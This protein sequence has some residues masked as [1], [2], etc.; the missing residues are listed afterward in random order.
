V[1]ADLN[2]AR[3]VDDLLAVARKVDPN[4]P[5]DDVNDANEFKDAV[6]DARADAYVGKADGVLRRVT[7]TARMEAGNGSGNIDADFT[8]SEVGKPQR[9]S[10]P[11][12]A[13]PFSQLQSDLGVGGFENVLRQGAAP[14]PGTGSA[15]PPAADSSA[16]RSKAPSADDQSYL[17]CVRRAT[18]AAA[19]QRCSSRLP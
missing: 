8:I 13:R 9:I 12:N 7:M 17:G 1:S 16:P 3:I 11:A 6:T 2:I 14:A 4:L 10:T 18:T 5:Q 15:P 19:L